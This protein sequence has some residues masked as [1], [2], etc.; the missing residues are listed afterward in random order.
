M[1]LYTLERPYSESMVFQYNY[2]FKS[3]QAGK[4]HFCNKILGRY[5]VDPTSSEDFKKMGDFLSK[6]SPT[7]KCYIIRSYYTAVSD[8]YR[9]LHRKDEDYSK[10]NIEYVGKDSGFTKVY[11]L[12]QKLSSAVQNKIDGTSYNTALVPDIC[13][14]AQV[15]LDNPAVFSCTEPK[16]SYLD[17]M[18]LI[19]CSNKEDVCDGGE[20]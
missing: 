11:E 20:V 15:A 12:C 1:T 5:E 9:W 17:A 10:T 6:Y 19:G 4:A 18:L 3:P 8:Y 7:E 14:E 13:C 16:S 2:N